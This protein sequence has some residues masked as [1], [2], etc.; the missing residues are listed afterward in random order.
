MGLTGTGAA[1]QYGIALLGQ[2]GTAGEIAHQRLVDG[3]AVELEV[4][5]VFGLFRWLFRVVGFLTG[6]K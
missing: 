1:D 3:R 6:T 2:E 5:E 4:I